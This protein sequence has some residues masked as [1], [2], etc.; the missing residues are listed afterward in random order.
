MSV[1]SLVF[2]LMNAVVWAWVL[3][4][5]SLGLTLIFGYL[6][7]VNVAHGV[8]YAIGA[9][10]LWS[11]VQAT[12]SA[13]GGFLLALVVAPLAVAIIGLLAFEVTI[14][15]IAR[16]PPIFTLVTTFG[17]MFVLQH[18][19]FLIFGG[20]PQS[21]DMPI[22]TLIPM[23]GRTYPVYR[24]VMAGIAAAIIVALWWFLHRSNYGTW[25]RAVQQNR[26]VA[27]AMGIPA[28][29]VTAVVFC[30]GSAL[31]G[32]AGVL[33]APVLQVRYDMGIDIIMDA[34]MVVIAAG[35]GNLPGTV[36]VAMVYQVIQAVFVMVMTPIQAKVIALSVVLTL[37]LVRR[38]GLLARERLK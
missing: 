22:A 14:R 27:T 2:Q 12:G 21:V 4:L 33:A 8:L 28:R 16:R 23:L 19:L 1:E 37:V 26:D 7:I 35:F 17:L 32:L 31:A 34:F 36:L 18:A 6:D 25:I 38:K 3:A 15:P 20:A 30:L 5:L 24:F 11:L 13:T 9:V 29:Q 10:I